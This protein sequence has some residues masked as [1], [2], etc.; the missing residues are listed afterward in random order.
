MRGL[1]NFGLSP[2]SVDFKC[3]RLIWRAVI[4]GIYEAFWRREVEERWLS[5][6]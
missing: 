6:M 1:S 3:I 2:G 5:A 4:F